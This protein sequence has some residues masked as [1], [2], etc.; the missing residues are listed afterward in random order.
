MNKL[1]QKT[2]SGVLWS[3]MDNGIS[4]VIQFVVGI[5]LARLLTPKEFGLIGMIIIFIYVSE[6][7]INSGFSQ[8]LIRK[9]NCKEEDYSTAFFFNFLMS[10]VFYILL[11]FAATPISRFYNQSELISILRI[12]G[13]LLFINAFSIV[14]Q[15][16]LI[17]NVDF[18]L[19]TKITFISSVLSGITSII[20]A[21][22]GYGVWS[23][24]AKMLLNNF[25]KTILLW[26]NNKWYP[27][28]F[29]SSHHF[30]EMFSFGYKLLLSGLFKSF[31]DN[32]YNLIIGK[33]FSVNELGFFT[34]ADRFTKLPSHTLTKT[35]QRVAFPVLSEIQEDIIHLKNGYK[36][37]I[38]ST[39]YFNSAIMLMLAAL[40]EP[41]ILTL[42]G[43]KWSQS[44]PFLQLLCLAQLMYPIISLNM[45]TLIVKGRSGLYLFL[46]I[47]SKLLIIPVVI[48]GIFTN[49]KIMILGMAAHALFSYLLISFYTSKMINYNVTDQVK[50]I[51]PGFLI[52]MFSAL[53]VFVLQYILILSPLAE[54]LLMGTVGVLLI[55]ILS[56]LFKET[57]YVEVKTIIKN[58]IIS[59]LH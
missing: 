30:K 32:I 41:V 1:R 55:I 39:M 53:P 47:I 8:A 56:E 24:V 45:N 22:K 42:L 25:F 52:A 27:T 16:I 11:F 18:R 31:F 29:F 19:Q 58:K 17:K 57:A 35:L 7:F 59:T 20:M 21:Y 9:N 49:I 26:F 28:S 5:I 48:L 36:H 6:V 51:L 37:F 38:K 23:L 46:E 10:T 44:I 54:L 15:A 33:F 12:L 40:A 14:Q 13:I 3:M 2:I 50:D 4:S 43:K 34:R